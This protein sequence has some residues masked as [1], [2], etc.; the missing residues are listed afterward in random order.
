MNS[1]VLAV[2]IVVGDIAEIMKSMVL[3]L[4]NGVCNLLT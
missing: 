1:V 3:T 4:N 2:D